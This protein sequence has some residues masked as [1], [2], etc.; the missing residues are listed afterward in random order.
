MS[1]NS[2]PIN[3]TYN[4]MQSEKDQFRTYLKKSGIIDALTKVLVAVY[5][6]QEKPKDSVEFL[7][8][9]LGPVIGVDIEALEKENA[10]LKAKIEQLSKQQAD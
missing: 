3:N 8:K 4:T 10:E 2:T 6:D 5:E 9:H 1:K 7:K